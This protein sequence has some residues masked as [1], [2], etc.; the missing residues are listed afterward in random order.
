MWIQKLQRFPETRDS[1]AS[2]GGPLARMFRHAW[3]ECT[4]LGSIG[5]IILE[6]RQSEGIEGFAW[7]CSTGR[8]YVLGS[9][10]TFQSSWESSV[11]RI[12]VWRVVVDNT[13]ILETTIPDNIRIE[14]IKPS[15]LKK[16][17]RLPYC[18]SS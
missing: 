14:S 12:M 16:E 4:P 7:R 3:R 8:K 11:L 6:E 10:K 9:S 15:V 5:D 18:Q 1:G 17:S 2:K 13:G